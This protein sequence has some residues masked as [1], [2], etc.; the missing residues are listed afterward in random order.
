MYL[1]L[2]LKSVPNDRLTEAIERLNQLHQLMARS[3]GFIEAQTYRYLGT[4]GQYLIVRTWLDSRAHQEYRATPEAKDFGIGRP[5]VMPYKNLAVQHWDEVMRSLGSGVGEF[6]VRS[7]H[8]VGAGNDRAYLASRHQQ[9][10]LALKVG[11]VVD[12]RTYRPISGVDSLSGAL[13]LERR[14][15][16]ASFDAY[17]ESVASNHYGLGV[18]DT[19]YTTEFIECYQLIQEVLPA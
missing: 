16:R 18:D 11:G 19:V 3:P 4:P 14:R 15:D 8:N 1:H 6:L 17:M 7:F 10:A 5:S 12:V 9:D 2:E 13:I